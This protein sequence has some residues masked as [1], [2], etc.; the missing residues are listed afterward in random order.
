MPTGTRL[1]QRSNEPVMPRPVRYALFEALIL[2]LF[3]RTRSLNRFP[4]ALLLITAEPNSV[5]RRTP[6]R[7][8]AVA[9]LTVFI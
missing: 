5:H 1:G 3:S 4:G 6:L 2:D 9:L 8:D 7:F